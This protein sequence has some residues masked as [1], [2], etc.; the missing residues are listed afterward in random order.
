[1][2]G[3]REIR[4]VRVDCRD[5]LFQTSN[6]RT[7]NPLLR[8]L[9]PKQVSDFAAEYYP[10]FMLFL[11][12]LI[13]IIPSNIVEWLNMWQ[14]KYSQPSKRLIKFYYYWYN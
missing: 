6:D 4:P 8:Y 5:G 12:D 1:M 13:G 3:R 14:R 10:V 11:L 7:T 9:M 2:V